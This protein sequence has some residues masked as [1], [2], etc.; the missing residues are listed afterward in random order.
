MTQNLIISQE[1]RYRIQ[2][3]TSL[4]VLLVCLLA[5]DIS[6]VIGC[7][8][9]AVVTAILPSFQL[10]SDKVTMINMTILLGTYALTSL[11]CNCFALHG[12]KR[13]NRM[14]LV[15]YLVFLPLVLT[16]IVILIVKN[17]L[18]RS[19][20]PEMLF[21]PMAVGLILMIVWLKL[22]RHWFLMSASIPNPSSA[23]TDLNVDIDIENLRL[24]GYNFTTPRHGRQG[25]GINSSPDLPP[26]YDNV[27]TSED[28]ED[29]PVNKVEETPPPAYQDVVKLEDEIK[30]Q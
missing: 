15:P 4:R 26:A 2:E 3:N 30:Q 16:S 17:I 28:T 13:E 25:A 6:A 19:V 29:R 27:V 12:L 24:R 8:S 7:V 21:I 1:Q 5:L 14:F 23:S 22:V 9:A 11:L 20:S 10:P 18:T